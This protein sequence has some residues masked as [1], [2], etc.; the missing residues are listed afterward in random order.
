MNH[1]QAQQAATASLVL[2][3]LSVILSIVLSVSFGA[4]IALGLGIIGLVLSV[5]SRKFEPSGM[6][7]AGFILSLVGA[8]MAGI[9]SVI[10]ITCTACV[11]SVIHRG[12]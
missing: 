7:T 10:N 9:F 2:G 11:S 12:F 4:Y 3:I 6:A 1:Q 5:S 8:I